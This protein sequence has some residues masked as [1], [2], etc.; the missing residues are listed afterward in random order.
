MKK[1]S[2]GSWAFAFGPYSE[3]PVSFV[4]TAKRLAEV[5]YDAIEICGIQEHITLDRYPTTE[6]RQ[7]VKKMLDDLGLERSGYA[8]DQYAFDPTEAANKEK[9]LEQFAKNLQ[10]C[11]DLGIRDIRVDTVADP[12]KY[13]SAAEYEAAKGR[14]AEVFHEAAQKAQDAGVRMHWEF[15]PGFIFNKPSEIVEMHGKV[16]HPNFDVMY[17]TSHAY[18]SAVAGSRQ[19]GEKETLAGGIDELFSNLEGK[20]GAIH[21]I[22]SDGSLHNKHTSTHNPFGTGNVDFKSIAPKLLSV[23]NVDYWAIDMCF[24]PG[25]WELVEASLAFVKRVI[26]EAEAAPAAS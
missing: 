10:M 18:M 24:W 13:S 4:K 2:L 6:S 25:S 21:L 8:C 19:Y 3:H 26:Q 12:V 15:E 23:P 11:N 9:Y 7:E 17:D 20:I 16:N 14:V 1:I 5:G 22:D